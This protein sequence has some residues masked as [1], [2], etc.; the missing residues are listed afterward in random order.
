MT[1]FLQSWH[2]AGCFSGLYLSYLKRHWAFSLH[3]SQTPS[4]IS[5][6]I[7]FS[8]ATSLSFNFKSRLRTN[9]T[10]CAAFVKPSVDFLQAM[11]SW[12]SWLR[13]IEN[14][15]VHYDML[16]SPLYVNLIFNGM[17]ILFIIDF[18]VIYTSKYNLIYNLIYF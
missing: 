11:I 15:S 17:F 5:F 16:F 10:F 8:C 13:E 7:F 12:R 2:L 6:W 4:H 1:L 14:R 9:L 3:R 18:E